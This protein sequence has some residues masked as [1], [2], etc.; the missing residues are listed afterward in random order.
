MLL[1]AFQHLSHTCSGDRD[2]SVALLSIK[3][4]N[5][6]WTNLCRTCI[7]HT[8]WDFRP[9]I[10]HFVSRLLTTLQRELGFL[11][12]AVFLPGAKIAY[13]NL[14]VEA[15]EVKLTTN[16]HS[17]FTFVCKSA[18]VTPCKCLFPV[19]QFYIYCIQVASTPVNQT[20]YQ[21]QTNANHVKNSK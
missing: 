9:C 18:S 6:P 10:P 4:P 5:Q 3:P 2:Q 8:I 16:N 21:T 14:P 1:V 12:P 7:I 15:P 11:A 20:T 17:I 13:V 19:V